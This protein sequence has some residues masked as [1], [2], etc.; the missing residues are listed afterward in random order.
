MSSAADSQLSQEIRTKSKSIS[1]PNSLSSSISKNEDAK[2]SNNAMFIESLDEYYRLKNKYDTVVKEKKNSIL[3]DQTLTLKQKREK[4]G[5]T[6]FKCIQCSRNVNT[7]FAINDGTLTAICGD[8]SNPCTL[9]IKINRGKYLDIRTL[10][11]VFQNGV[12]DLKDTIISVKLDLLFGYEDEK[13]TLNKFNTLKGELIEDLE[14]VAEYKTIYIGAIYNLKNK[15][16]LQSKTQLF[17]QYVNTIKETIKEF[18]ETGVIHLI[19]DVISLYQ[20]ELKPIV[21][22]INDLTYQYRSIEYD[23]K[24]NS[25]R[26]KRDIYTTTDILVPFVEPHV[27]AFEYGD[28]IKKDNRIDN[29][30]SRSVSS[31]L[32]VNRFTND[33]EDDAIGE[34]DITD[35]ANKLSP[36]NT[37]TNTNSGD[38]DVGK[39]IIKEIDGEKRIFLGDKE[40][41]N[42]VDYL[43]NASIYT[44]A[45]EIDATMASKKGYIM[46]MI[47]TSLGNPK[48]I[49]IDVTNGMIYKVITASVRK[50]VPMD[51]YSSDSDSDSDIPPPP[52]SPPI[53]GDETE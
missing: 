24:Q 23:D 21:A 15:E 14:A 11:D 32:D 51:V 49:A 3:K 16:S 46:E 8:T 31:E 25:Y 36:T 33:T 41:L 50:A 13:T 52:P 44:D 39:V 35:D 4:Y 47:N 34:D 28:S 17:Y 26:L 6:K 38:D 22:N 53:S 19:K 12:D 10:M 45:P 40:I 18:N 27:E 43:K 42:K 30:E 5:K 2:I 1:S 7:I 29:V 9:N 20:T 48:L 37:N